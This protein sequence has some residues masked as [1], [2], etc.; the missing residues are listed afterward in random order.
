MQRIPR[1]ALLDTGAAWSLIPKRLW[2]Q[3]QTASGESMAP[4]GEIR[5]V[6]ID[7]VR[8]VPDDV[9]WSEGNPRPPRPILNADAKGEEGEEREEEHEEEEEEEGGREDDDVTEAEAESA[10][11]D[12]YITVPDRKRKRSHKKHFFHRAKAR[13]I[14]PPSRCQPPRAAKRTREDASSDA[15]EPVD[16]RPRIAVMQRRGPRASSCY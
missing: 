14:L 13:R 9:T 10:A 15:D 7:R 12:D 2:K 8:V 11:A 3:L 1:N 6:S 4:I 16:R 5:Q